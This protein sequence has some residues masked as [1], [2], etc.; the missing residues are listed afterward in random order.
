MSKFDVFN[1]QRGHDAKLGFNAN[2]NYGS[3]RKS[4]AN[5][6][7]QRPRFGRWSTAAVG[8]AGYIFALTFTDR[9]I[10]FVRYA[11]RFYEQFQRGYFTLIDHDNGG[12]EHVGRFT[13]YADDTQTANGKYTATATFEDIPGCSMRKYPNDWANSSHLI[14]VIDDDGNALVG[15]DGGAWVFQPNP[16]STSGTISLSDTSA[17]L[18][19]VTPVPSNHQLFLPSSDSDNF[20]QM[21]YIGWGFRMTLPVAPFLSFCNIVVDGVAVVSGLDLYAGTASATPGA[22]VSGGAGL[23]VTILKEDLPLG[24][25]RVKVQGTGEINSSATGS[26]L[27]FP[28]IRVMH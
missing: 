16:L 17:I 15:T 24:R 18:A 8:D 26:G 25:H 20:A 11:K 21:E 19:T 3:P 7:T 1:P 28:A 22:K 6:Q 10:E 12:R 27:V 2:W 14:D 13:N 9:P 5:Y 23:P 4:P